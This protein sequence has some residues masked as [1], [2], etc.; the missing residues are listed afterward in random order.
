MFKSG[1]SPSNQILRQKKCKKYLTKLSNMV[2]SWDLHQGG[3]KLSCQ[4]VKIDQ[5]HIWDLR[6]ATHGQRRNRVGRRFGSNK[7][8]RGEAPYSAMRR[9]QSRR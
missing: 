6:Q 3:E 9:V 8:L 7:P 1:F 5:L 2:R 4:E